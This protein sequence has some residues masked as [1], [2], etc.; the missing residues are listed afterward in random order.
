M[1]RK[2]WVLLW[3][4]VAGISLAVMSIVLF[5]PHEREGA[6]VPPAFENQAT[7]GVPAVPEH[8]G[9][10]ELYQEGMAYR[11]GVCGMVQTNEGEA[12]VFF[13]N[14]RENEAWLKLRLLDEQGTLLG[15]SG[16]LK[17]GEYL[18]AVKLERALSAGAQ[19]KLHVMGYQPDTYRSIGAVTLNAITTT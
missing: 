13:T 17:P 1:L 19:I 2:R 7:V 11:V 9:Y 6:F 5:Q 8:L 4:L 18:R 14:L 15:E 3:I 16:L 10:A 12:V